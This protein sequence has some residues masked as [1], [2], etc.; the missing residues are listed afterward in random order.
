MVRSRSGLCGRVSVS[1]TSTLN[2]ILILDGTL[3]FK[4]CQGSYADLDDED[5]NLLMGQ[6]LTLSLA[7]GAGSDPII[8]PNPNPNPDSPD[9]DP[10]PPPSA[11]L[12]Y[13]THLCPG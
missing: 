7:Y 6:V 9:V 8:S 1:I 11:T 13:I 12:P 2:L 10:L 5:L 4:K 3:H